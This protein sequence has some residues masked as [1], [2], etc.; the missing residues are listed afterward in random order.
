MNMYELKNVK[1]KFNNFLL[2]VDNCSINE[3]EIYV[4][5]GPNGCGKS[6]F[7]NILS[8]LDTQIE[9]ELFFKEKKVEYKNQ[10]TLIN[11]RKRI[12]CQMQNPY[13][14][15]MSVFDNISYGLKLRKFSRDVI[16]EKVTR[17]LFNLAISHLAKR[18]T[19]SL[20]GG[21]AQRVAL[22]RTLVLDSDVFLLD[23]P[24]ANVDKANIGMVE[25]LIQ[26][27]NKEKKATF[28]ITTHS[29]QQAYRLS[30]NVISIFNGRINNITY[31]NVFS[32]ALKE[33]EGFLKSLALTDNLKIML[34]HKSGGRISV[35]IDPQDIIISKKRIKSSALNSFCGVINKIE[36][37]NG[38]LQVFVDIGV[39]FCA[40]VTSKSFY[41]MGLNIGKKVWITFKASA[42]QV[43]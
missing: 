41:K 42:V 35:A 38:S 26:A 39:D 5:I 33:E 31:E 43:I 7:L 24:T 37:N 6:T 8:L 36:N 22:A 10:G 29:H 4:V 21:E 12:S 28:V 27:L 30:S 9:G 3:G 23:E 15:N 20:S 13:L 2:N 11:M 40:V 18:N 34:N 32:G 17:I 16:K 25:K 19:H 14:F 1:R